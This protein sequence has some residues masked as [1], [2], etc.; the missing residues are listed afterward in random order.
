[1]NTILPESGDKKNIRGL[2]E[3]KA[4]ADIARNLNLVKI[5]TSSGK[6]WTETSVRDFRHHYKIPVFDP[7]KY[8]KKGWVNLQEAARIL[9]TSSTAVSRLIQAKILQARQIIKYSSWII[10]KN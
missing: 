9:G 7:S 5:Q 2:A 4:D 8:E 3:L 1:L 6:S 10:E